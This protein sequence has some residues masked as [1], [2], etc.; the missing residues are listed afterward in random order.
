[1]KY[2]KLVCLFTFLTICLVAP[3]KAYINDIPAHGTNIVDVKP[4]ES[5]NQVLSKF[6]SN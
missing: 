4:G 1:M 3:Y 2:F 5:I 6:L